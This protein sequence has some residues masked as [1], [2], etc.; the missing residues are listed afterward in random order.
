[1]ASAATLTS[2]QDLPAALQWLQAR[3][4]R[5]LTTDTR[6]LAAG[7]AF[8]AW[9]GYAH[10]GRGYVAQAL[11]AGASAC[12]VEAEGVERHGFND[13][14]IAAMAG[15]KAS[16][17]L[18]ADAFYGR[19]SAALEVLAVTGTNGKTSTAWWLAQAL[20]AV[21]LGAGVIGTLGVGVPPALVS[22]GLTTPDPV[23]LHQSFR[24]F[25]DQ[26]LKAAAIEAS[27][28]GLAES[29]LSGARITVALFTNFTQDHLDYHGS[30]EAYWA[31]KQ[32][33]FEWPGLRAAVVNMDDPTGQM[34][35]ERLAGRSGLTLMTYGLNPAAQLRS[36]APRHEPEA[37]VLDVHEAGTGS[38]TV[39]APL[40]GDF[41]ALNL[42][43]VLGGLRALGVPLGQAALACASLSAVPGR[44]QRVTAAAGEAPLGVVDYAHTP[45]ALEKALLAL[46]PLAA[47]RGGQ[48]VCVFGCGGNRDAGKRPLMGAIAAREADRVILTSDNPRLES[49]QDILK[50]IQAGVPAGAAVRI[51]PD[52]ARAIAQAVR[53]AGV[54]DVILVAGKGHE[55]DQD[56]GGVKH[57][58]SDP[59][60]LQAAL[61]GRVVS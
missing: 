30:M 58:F 29:R 18:I 16:T 56:I 42:L 34:L 45:D 33:L 4:A 1:M 22:T 41:N 46:R 20:H 50:D 26:G 37:M 44:M 48:L 61:D 23:T 19:P 8:I 13:P 15:L 32:A 40:I 57:A 28:I 7:D 14:R 25:V 39:R 60:H 3:G 17:G 21:G 51:E 24:R 10:D 53:E 54:R 59:A 35:A 47:A 38:A 9:P 2:L 12:L 31:A 36:A 6:R 49:T 11:E 5:G 27:S 52:R 43:A 55:A